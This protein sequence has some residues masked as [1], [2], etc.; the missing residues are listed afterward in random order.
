MKARHHA[1]LKIARTSD[2]VRLRLR[3]EIDAHDISQ[4]TLAELL[5][6][7]TGEAWSKSKVA[8]VLSGHVQLLVDDADAIAKIVGL[9]LTEAVR[10]RGLEFYAE[11]SPTELKIL[12][13]MRKRPEVLQAVML[14]VGVTPPE[15]QT[16]NFQKR[17]KPGRPLNSSLPKRAASHG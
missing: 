10:D 16:P 17:L 2:R 3:E 15:N 5:T 4:Q 6:K 7:E 12:E 9:Y 8:H 11:M 1:G 14:L 13:R